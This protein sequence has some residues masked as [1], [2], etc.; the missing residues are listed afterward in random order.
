MT[1][2]LIKNMGPVW[3]WLKQLWDSLF[4][5]IA[6][7]DPIYNFLKGFIDIFRDLFYFTF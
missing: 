2:F 3:A 6:W 4:L 7:A 1:F 5:D